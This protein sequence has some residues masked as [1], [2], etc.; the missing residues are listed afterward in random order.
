MLDGSASVDPSHGPDSFPDGWCDELD[1][2]VRGVKR[3]RDVRGDAG[4]GAGEAGR[5][6]GVDPALRLD[7]SMRRSS[8]A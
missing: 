6:G 5:A 7:L 2:T 3:L 4:L 1:S 8:S